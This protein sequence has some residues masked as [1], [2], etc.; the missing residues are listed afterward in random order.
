MLNIWRF[1]FCIPALLAVFVAQAEDWQQG[2]LQMNGS[3]QVGACGI[4]SGS[5]EQTVDFSSLPIKRISTAAR[6]S[7]IVDSQKK[8]AIRLVNCVLPAAGGLTFDLLFQGVPS[9]L[10]A[11]L[12]RVEGEA[13]GVAIELTNSKEQL[14]P[15][16]TRVNVDELMSTR[17][18][19]VFHAALRSF[20]KR[21][22]AGNINSMVQLTLRYF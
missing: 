8:F 9:E 1:A 11:Q 17:D 21:L 12:L 20:G 3:I 5:M 22:S 4:D 19:L 6:G 10:D 15:L 18:L 13:K 7:R 14:I 16:G 2:R